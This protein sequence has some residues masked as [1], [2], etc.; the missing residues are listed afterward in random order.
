MEDSRDRLVGRYGPA[1]VTD[2]AGRVIGVLS[3]KDL[4]ERYTQDPDARPH[5]IKGFYQQVGDESFAEDFSSYETTT[6]A[7]ETA[8]DI[9]TAQVFSVESDTGMRELATKM[10]ELDVHRLLV[11]KQKKTVGIVSTMDVI[12]AI[13]ELED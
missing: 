5:R 12:K 13:A 3:L 8:Q 10:V 9:M 1:P 2:E 6:E 11:T 4:V 7:E